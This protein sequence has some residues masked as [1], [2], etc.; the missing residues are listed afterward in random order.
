MYIATGKQQAE[1]AGQRLKDMGFQYTDL[2]S[3]TMTRA[4]QTADI[5]SKY[6][7]DVERSRTELLNEGAPIPPEPPVGSWRPEKQVMCTVFVNCNFV[8]FVCV[9]LNIV[10]NN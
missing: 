8:C 2:I 6:I 1:F 10:Y 7:P 3:S 4:I 5:I 9:L